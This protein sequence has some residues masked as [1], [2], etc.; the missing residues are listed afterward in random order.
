M[1]A[2]S[3]PCV[4][5]RTPGAQII[6]MPGIAVLMVGG[7]SPMYAAKVVQAVDDAES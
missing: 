2:R 7:P 6:E 3:E 1:A 5:F 4:A